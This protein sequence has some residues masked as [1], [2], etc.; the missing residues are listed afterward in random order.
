MVM[1]VRSRRI[2]TTSGTPLG[3]VYDPYFNRT[4]EHFCS[5]QHAPARPEPSGFHCGVQKGP[6]MYLAH[7]VFRLYAELGA[8]AHRAYAL[9]ALR[10]SLG[11]RRLR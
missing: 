11:P 9:A 7:P 5:H 2:R 4:Y 8:V 10:N 3:E 6:V 1:Y